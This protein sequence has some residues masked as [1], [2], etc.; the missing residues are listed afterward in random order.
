MKT[1]NMRKASTYL[2]LAGVENIY[3]GRSVLIY[4]GE[5]NVVCLSLSD[6]QVSGFADK[7]DQVFKP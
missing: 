7:Y 1:N 4:I 5:D 6:N 3:T 2:E